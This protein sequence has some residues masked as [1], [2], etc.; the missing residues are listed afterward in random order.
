MSVGTGTPVAGVSMIT[1]SGDRTQLTLSGVQR[2]VDGATVV[3]SA[4]GS[5]VNVD[6]DPATLTVHC[7]WKGETYHTIINPWRTR[8]AG[9]P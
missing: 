7:K 2:K 6:S 4:M 1:V 3:C 8:A 9:L 5:A